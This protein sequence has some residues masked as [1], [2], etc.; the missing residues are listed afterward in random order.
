[1]PFAFT[2]IKF[3]GQYRISNHILKHYPAFCSASRAVKMYF[4]SVILFQVHASALCLFEIS[5]QCLMEQYLVV[6]TLCKFLYLARGPDC[7]EQRN[8]FGPWIQKVQAEQDVTYRKCR[9]RSVY[10][11]YSLFKIYS[12]VSMIGCFLQVDKS[13]WR[14]SILEEGEGE[15]GLKNKGY[16]ESN[17]P[18]F[19]IAI[20]FQPAVPLCKNLPSHP[21]AAYFLKEMLLRLFECLVKLLMDSLSPVRYIFCV[22]TR[23]LFD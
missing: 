10:W 5:L 15:G 17:Q 19:L 4:Y 11:R 3:Q 2:Q 20:G 22:P 23:F 12:L 18:V 6:E 1:M 16:T 14:I 21:R 7:S 13:F 9:W 8:S